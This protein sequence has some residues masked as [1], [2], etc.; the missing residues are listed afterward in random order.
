MVSMTSMAGSG[1]PCHDY[2][3]LYPDQSRLYKNFRELG[4]VNWHNEYTLPIVCK[5]VAAIN[6]NFWKFRLYILRSTRDSKIVI[7][8]KI[9]IAEVMIALF[10]S[11]REAIYPG[12]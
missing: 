9:R 10:T 7:Q 4:L 11:T 12:R 3:I 5:Y 1:R 8:V 6:S 2:V